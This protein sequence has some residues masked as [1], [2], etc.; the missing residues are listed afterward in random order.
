MKGLTSAS[1][2]AVILFPGLL[3]LVGMEK[4]IE[5]PCSNNLRLCHGAEVGG[6]DKEQI[7][8]LFID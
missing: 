5:C 7:K 6:Q 4:N 8:D 3:D 2:F 1:L